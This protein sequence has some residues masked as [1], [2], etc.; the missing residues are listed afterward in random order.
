MPPCFRFSSVACVRFLAFGYFF[1]S[2]RFPAAVFVVVSAYLTNLAF[3]E[4]LGLAAMMVTFL[5]ETRDM[6]PDPVWDERLTAA[7]SKFTEL[8]DR[9][10]ESMS[11]WNDR[12]NRDQS[13]ADENQ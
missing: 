2:L 5:E 9:A 1:E 10:V 12:G 8:K 13:G 3:Y 11:E 6:E 7:S 4:P